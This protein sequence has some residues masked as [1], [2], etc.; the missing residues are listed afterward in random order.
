VPERA[1]ERVPRQ[2][3]VE[4]QAAPAGPLARLPAMPLPAAFGDPPARVARCA[5]RASAWRSGS[6][7]SSGILDRLGLGAHHA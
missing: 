7:T 6:R 5:Q 3:L 4:L 1:I 2:L